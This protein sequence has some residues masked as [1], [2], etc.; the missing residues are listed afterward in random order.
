MAETNEDKKVTSVG[1]N[2]HIAG[3]SVN[4]TVSAELFDSIY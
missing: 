3:G 2:S 4:L 1:K